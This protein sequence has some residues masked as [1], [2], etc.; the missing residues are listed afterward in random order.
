MPIKV[1]G[2]DGVGGSFMPKASRESVAR[3]IVEDCAEKGQYENR[4]PVICN[5]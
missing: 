1:L 4:T 2:D 3:F 5:T